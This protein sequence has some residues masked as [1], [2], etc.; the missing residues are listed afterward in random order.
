MAFDV[1]GLAEYIDQTRES[2][3]GKLYFE[4]RT[5]QYLSDM[6]G[7]KHKEALQIFDLAAYPQVDTACEFAASGSQTFTQRTMTVNP[8]KYEDTMCPKTLRKKWTQI[9]L[10]A[11]SGEKEQ[12][13]ESFYGFLANELI[14]LVGNN[15]ET[16]MWQGNTTSGNPVL[17]KMD[18]FIKLIDAASGVNTA[19][20]VTYSAANAKTIVDNCVAARPATLVTKMNQVLFCGTDFFMLYINKLIDT[21]YY[22]INP[23]VYANYTF[24][25]P[26]TNVT[27]VG[28]HGLDGTER[29][30][31]GES[32][33][34]WRGY[35]L[36]SDSADMDMWYSKDDRNVKYHLSF[37]LGV[38]IARPEYIVEFT[39]S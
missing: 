9:L 38:Q 35:D 15:N 11:G 19:T 16:A 30:F 34:F 24:Q 6:P 23:N 27:L 14:S 10:R 20:A 3:I 2:L 32:N 25:I 37:K 17:S 26:G 22:N 36:E 13:N 12:P 31:L 5:A 39:G 4:N 33:N 28:V 18:G 7:V 21:N 29:L 8:I 1:S